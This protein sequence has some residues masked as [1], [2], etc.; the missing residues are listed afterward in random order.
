MGS[1]LDGKFLIGK[2]P[3]LELVRRVINQFNCMRSFVEFD[4]YLEV[5]QPRRDGQT[6]F[7]SEEIM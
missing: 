7:T 6:S 2:L 1:L 3:S 5:T 4:Y